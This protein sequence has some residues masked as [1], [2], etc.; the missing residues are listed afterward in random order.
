MR[1]TADASGASMT[2]EHFRHLTDG[3]TIRAR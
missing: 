1:I 3:V 2:N